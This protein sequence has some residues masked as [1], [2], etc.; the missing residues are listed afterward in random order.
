[1]KSTKILILTLLWIVLSAS[2]SMSSPRI[3]VLLSTEL[4]NAG[5]SKGYVFPTVKLECL[6][7]VSVDGKEFPEG[8][9]I[10]I[11]PAE[12]GLA[13]NNESVEQNVLT[14]K[15]RVKIINAKRSFG[16]PVYEDTIVVKKV[17]K[18]VVVLNELDLETYVKFV[19]PS[20]VPNWFEKEAI[21]AQTVAAR[22][23]ALWD[24]LNGPKDAFYGAH[25]DDSTKSQV[26]NNQLVTAV[27]E[28]AVRET[29]GEVLFKDGKPID[30]IVYFSTSS[31]FTSNNE[32]VWSD[33]QGNFPGS[34]IGYLRS[35][36]QFDKFLVEEDD[37]DERFWHLFLMSFWGPEKELCNFYDRESPWFRWKVTM[38]RE[39]LENSISKGLVAREKADQVLKIDAVRTVE[40]K[41]IDVNDPNFSIGELKDLQI[42]RRGQGGVVMTLRILAENG[43]YEMDKEYNIRFT[44]RPTKTITGF[45]RDIVIETHNGSRYVNYS[46]LPSGYFTFII[47]RSDDGKIEHVTFYGGGNGH[48]VGMSQYGANYLAKIG[49]DYKQIL[50]TFYEATVEKM[51]Q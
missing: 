34:P 1:M 5:N 8:S 28:E 29:E 44:I 13:L 19:V 33:A 15:G 18:G 20:E 47:E 39:E 43:V 2:L 21:K 50:T 10:E 17:D 4:D 3:A 7:P 9:V 25:C 32:E 37:K 30:T 36:K 51:T 35:K 48:G 6:S 12:N 41:P 38:T 23:R 40:G 22:S 27:I 14:I 46:I 16:N 11:A 24:F 31:G 42:V 45:D 26:F 49:R